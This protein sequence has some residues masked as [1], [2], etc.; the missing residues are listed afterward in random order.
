MTT[1]HSQYKYFRIGVRYASTK[2]VSI[3]R[4]KYQHVDYKIIL[5]LSFTNVDFL[6]LKICFMEYLVILFGFCMFRQQL[7]LLRV[8]KYYRKKKAKMFINQQSI[9]A[10]DVVIKNNIDYYKMFFSN[11]F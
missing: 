11:I 9:L 5:H 7:Y 3:Y 4:K 6:Y 2:S 8:S 10:S 1:A